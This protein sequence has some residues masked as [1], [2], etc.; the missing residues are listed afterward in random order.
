MLKRR[1]FSA[2]ASLLL[3]TPAWAQFRVEISGVGATQLP[4]AIAKFR[5]EERAGQS[6]SAIVRADLE[7][8]GVFRGIDAPAVLDERAQ[9]AMSEW[10]GRTADALVGGSVT[11]LADGRF[12][13]RFKLWDVVKGVELGGQSNSVDL[14]DLRLAA[15]R[16][17]DYVYERLTGENAPYNLRFVT[18]G[19]ACTTASLIAAALGI[20]DLDQLTEEQKQQI[21]RVHL[22][23]AMYNA[24]QPGVFALSGWDL[25][26]ALPLP[27][28][29]RRIAIVGGMANLGVMGGGGGSSQVIPPGG[30]ALQMP[31]GG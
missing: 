27:P 29:T 28:S 2:A 7:R 17:A 6:I 3:A 22:L 21:Q 30:F 19:V 24:F 20:R 1:Q 16:I 15:H 8:S 5:D 4:I 13:V 23:L 12:D 26:G 10:R 14:A 11:R 25:V 9:P 31:L 18:N